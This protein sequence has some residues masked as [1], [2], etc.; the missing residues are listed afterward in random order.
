MQTNDMQIFTHTTVD[1]ER[2]AGN[3]GEAAVGP[4]AQHRVN[5]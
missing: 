4:L 2:K 3:Q 5:T 1:G